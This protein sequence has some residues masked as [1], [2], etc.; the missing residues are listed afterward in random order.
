MRALVS[1]IVGSVLS[2]ITVFG[3]RYFAHRNE[4]LDVA[5]ERSSHT[6]S[7]PTGGGLAIATLTLLGVWLYF[8]FRPMVA[9]SSLLAYTIGALTIIAI[10]WLDDL[11][12]QPNWLR[13]SIHSA[14][15]LLAIY[16][17][18]YLPLR[19]ILPGSAW[20]IESLSVAVTFLWIVGLTYAYN[21]MWVIDGIA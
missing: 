7:V 5:N 20:L 21:F 8:S 10:S 13:F 2:Y 18:G 1:F 4:I 19:T 9:T 12:S 14:A 16:G 11:Y 3:V 15:A 6:G 17:F